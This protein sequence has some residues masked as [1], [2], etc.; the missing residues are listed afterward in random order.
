[1]LN[2]KTPYVRRFGWLFLLLALALALALALSSGLLMNLVRPLSGATGQPAAQEP[3]GQSAAE[4][5]AAQALSQQQPG[6]QV[7]QVGAYTAP[8]QPVYVVDNRNGELSSQILVVDSATGQVAQSIGT[9]YQPD[10][11]VTR[12]R[13]YIVDSYSPT[14]AGELVNGLT[15]VSLP[16]GQIQRDVVALPGLALYQRFPRQSRVALAPSGKYLYYQK[17]MSVGV[18][19][20]ENFTL[21]S[22]L[23]HPD[24]E[25]RSFHAA[26]NATYVVCGNGTVVAFNQQTGKANRTVKTFDPSVQTA[27]GGNLEV[28]AAALMGNRLVVVN[29]AGQLFS[30]SEDLANV[31]AAAN[32]VQEAEWEVAAPASIALS[33]D[34][35]RLYIS[36]SREKDEAHTEGAAEDASSSSSYGASQIDAGAY[37]YLT[38]Q[39]WV[40]DTR[41]WKRTSVIQPSQPVF[42]FSLS[43]D[44]QLL[45]GVTPFEQKLLVIQTADG[46]EVSQGR[47]GV[48]PALVVPSAGGGA[49]N[50]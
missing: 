12:D 17:A 19:D 32:L 3:A 47:L 8:A 29:N 34:Q 23:A 45:Y 14:G 44:G 49:K 38:E 20:L 26:R 39:I 21:Q 33:P 9:R 1:M 35:Q 46:R 4:P 25:P 11:A 43:Q 37:E 24:C 40:F 6:N 27:E 36:F 42:T 15:V 48:T 30:V 2:T 50:R 18:V 31:S 5:Q 10:L 16:D 28:Q 7:P 13:L 41:S 22:D